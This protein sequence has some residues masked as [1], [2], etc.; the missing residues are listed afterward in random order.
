M[1]TKP[2]Q[3]FTPPTAVLNN[4]HISGVTE[5]TILQLLFWAICVY[6]VIYT[7]VAIYHWLRYSHGS[8]VAFPAIIVH[9]IVSVLLLLFALSGALSV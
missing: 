5:S 7:L 2:L 9:L 6:W 1:P 3:P 4:F 8:L